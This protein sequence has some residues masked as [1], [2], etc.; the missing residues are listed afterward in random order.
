MKVAGIAFLVA[1]ASVCFAQDWLGDVG[2][3]TVLGSAT[4]GA[5]TLFVEVAEQVV[6]RRE[7]ILDSMRRHGTH[8]VVIID[9]SYVHVGYWMSSDDPVYRRYHWIVFVEN[10]RLMS[11][12]SLDD[13]VFNAAS[14]PK[15]NPQTVAVAL[16]ANSNVQPRT[17]PRPAYAAPANPRNGCVS[18]VTS[19]G[20]SVRCYTDGRLTYQQLCTVNSRTFAVTCRSDSY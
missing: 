19:T 16:G 7:Q 10:T 1:L 20:S 18:S 4:N 17:L 9:P 5:G 12:L 3:F 8:H 2:D 13:L 6:G 14:G 15:L 11:G